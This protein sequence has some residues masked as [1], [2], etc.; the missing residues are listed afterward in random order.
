MT[1]RIKNLDRLNQR[2]KAVRE[3]GAASIPAV[4]YEEAETIIGLAKEQYVPVDT[5]ALRGSGFVE[6]PVQTGDRVEVRLGFGGP[7]APYALTV[8]EDLTAYHPVGQAKYLETPFRLRVS[9]LD[10]VVA[11]KARQ[12]ITRGWQ[13]LR[14]AERRVAR[15][16]A[17]EEAFFGG[18]GDRPPRGA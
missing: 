6:P 1:F 3:S 7:A 13:T 2:L 4:L 9:G 11:A 10:D 16:V 12:D 14:K 15:R 8:H 18:A 5:G 17:R